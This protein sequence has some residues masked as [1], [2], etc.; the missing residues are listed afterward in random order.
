MFAEGADLE[1]R[2]GRDLAAPDEVYRQ[3]VDLSIGT[4][5]TRV[6]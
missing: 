6:C 1:T 4:N 3:L 5:A 2:D